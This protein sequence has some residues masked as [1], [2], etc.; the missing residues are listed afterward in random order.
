MSKIKPSTLQVR[1]G[2][3][4]EIGGR[5]LQVLKANHTQGAGRQLGNVQVCLANALFWIEDT[6]GNLVR[7]L[8]RDTEAESLIKL[9]LGMGPTGSAFRV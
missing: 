5:L 3:V 4:L 7:E 2:N 1:P 9:A 8:I 6:G